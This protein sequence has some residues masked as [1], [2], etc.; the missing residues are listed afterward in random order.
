MGFLL[1]YRNLFQSTVSAPSN[2]QNNSRYLRFLGFTGSFLDASGG[3]GWGTVVTPTLMTTSTMEPR[4]IIG[5]VSASEFIVALSA[6]AGFLININKI[7]ID[8]SIVGGLAL[9]GA[10]MAPI[11]AKLVAKFPRKPLAILVGIAIIVI[12][13]LRIIQG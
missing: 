12:N 10:L 3:G 4:K 6:S 8:W 2:L 9:G 11:A 1:L 13:G 5:T 7:N